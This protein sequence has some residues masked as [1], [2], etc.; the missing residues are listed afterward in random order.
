MVCCAEKKFVYQRCE[1]YYQSNEHS[2]K[3][4]FLLYSCP[5]NIITTTSPHVS[6]ADPNWHFYLIQYTQFSPCT[7]S[8]CLLVL[9]LIINNPNKYTLLTYGTLLYEQ[10]CTPSTNNMNVNIILV[11]VLLPLSTRWITIVQC[12]LR[13]SV[14][15]VHP[16]P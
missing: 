7:Y 14:H 2:H 5:Q 16:K 15:A 13:S 10:V 11:H 8:H 3:A 12:T 9:S 1:Q 4:I 6:S